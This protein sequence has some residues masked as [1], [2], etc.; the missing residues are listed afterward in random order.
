MCSLL[1][2]HEL[3]AYF[4]IVMQCVLLICDTF[5]E[6]LEK[7]SNLPFSVM[8]LPFFK[9]KDKEKKLVTAELFEFA[10]F[11]LDRDY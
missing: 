8:K 1:L 6:I 5:L 3:S 7:I 9:Y 4:G 2:N 11:E 10:V